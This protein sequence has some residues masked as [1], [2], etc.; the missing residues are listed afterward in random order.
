MEG[1]Y[2]PTMC[3]RA[4]ARLTS[5]KGKT[6]DAAHDKKSTYFEFVLG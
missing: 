1:A 2:T 6:P 4:W 5:R 3:P